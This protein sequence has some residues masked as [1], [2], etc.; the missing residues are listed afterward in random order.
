MGRLGFGGWTGLVLCTVCAAVGGGA[1]GEEFVGPFPSWRNLQTHYSAKGD[2]KADDTAAI[3]EALDELRYHEAF[4]VLYVPAGTYRI[5]ETVRLL[6]ESHTQSQ[7]VTICGEDP[8]TTTIA[9]DGAAGGVMFD[10]GSWFSSVGRLTFD[11]C[12]KA[13]TAILH[14]PSFATANEFH[15]MVFRDLAFGIEAG[16]ENGIAETAVLRCRFLRCSKAGVSIQGF[17]CLDWYVWHCLFEDCALGVSNEFGAGNFHVY[18]SI[19][20]RSTE[21]DVSTKHCGYFSLYR[22]TSLGSKAF[23]LGKRHQNWSADDTH[24]CEFTIQENTIIDPV[25]AACIRVGHNGPVLLLDNRIRSRGDA[26]GTAVEHDCPETG[27]FI[28]IGNTFTVAEPLSGVNER[29]FALD[30]QTIEAAEMATPDPQPVAFLPRAQRPIIEVEPGA[31]AAK[32]QAAINSAAQLRGQRPVVRVPKGMYN[33]RETLT[34]PAG[35]DVQLVGDGIIEATRLNGAGADPVIRVVG[36][37]HATLRNLNITAGKE[38]AAIVV[39]GCDQPGARVFAEQL[40]SYG[41]GRGLSVE[42]LDEAYVELRNHGHNSMSVGGGPRLAKGE[43]APG[44]VALFCGASS[45]HTHHAPDISLYAVENGGRLL[46]RDIWYEGH[47]WSMLR[48]SGS[49][50]FT[51]HS[52]LYAPYSAGDKNFAD[53]PFEKELRQQT[54]PMELNGFK[55][56]VLLSQVQTTGAAL[57]DAQ[58][59]L[60]LKGESR[61]TSLLLCGHVTQAKVIDLSAEAVAA[62]RAVLLGGRYMNYSEGGKGSTS[63][64]ARG[65][66]DPEFVRE[67]LA[68]LRTRKPQPHAEYREGVTDVRFLRVMVDGKDG[69]RLLP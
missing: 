3:Q 37:S 40:Q 1:W 17:N 41:H 14:G 20:R 53:L 34:I 25:D 57:A 2:G 48:L 4:N 44:Y 18:E 42:G 55:G 60:S 65:V 11:G 69:V 43:S 47:A 9:W 22:N 51:H 10:Y 12:G 63:L 39:D 32:I 28:A 15:D 30:N 35:C 45:R 54:A 31:D 36:P 19:F 58:P 21:A 7:G 16:Q 33:V 68:P 61:E 38:A 24:P 50:E 52:G 59:F 5:T 13:K 27:D 29:L 46:V 66:A 62:G 64:D 6:R 67:M 8:E 49:G 23:Y 26:E 56:R